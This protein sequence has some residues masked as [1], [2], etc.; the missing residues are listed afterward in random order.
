ML[1][2]KYQCYIK[3]KAGTM[4]NQAL[5]LKKIYFS[6]KKHLYN[7]TEEL[8]THYLAGIFMNF[9]SDEK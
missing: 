7:I 8:E 1:F 4:Y 5:N 9:F 6:S 3:H 2:I